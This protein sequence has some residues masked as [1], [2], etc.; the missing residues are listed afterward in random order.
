MFLCRLS[1]ISHFY[2][3]GFPKTKMWGRG[4]KQHWGGKDSLQV[5][6]SVLCCQHFKQGD[7]D[8]TGQI[9]RLRDGVFPSRYLKIIILVIL[10]TFLLK[11]LCI[12]TLHYSIIIIIILAGKGQDYISLQK[13]WRE[14]LHGLSGCPT[15]GN[16]Q[17]QPNGVSISTLNIIS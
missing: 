14:S 16:P 1:Q 4:G 2:F 7:F 8:R 17:P 15:N 11:V 9:V 10:N 6:S 13:S 3:E 12:I 5:I